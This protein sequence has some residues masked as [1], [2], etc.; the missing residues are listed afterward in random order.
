MRHEKAFLI[1]KWYDFGR[2]SI[3]FMPLTLC[4]ES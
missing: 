1:N 4:I 2:I 3:Y